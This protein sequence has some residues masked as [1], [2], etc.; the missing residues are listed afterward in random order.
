MSKP[1]TSAKLTIYPSWSI[2]SPVQVNYLI[3]AN[4]GSATL[5]VRPSGLHEVHNWM[6][7]HA[8]GVKLEVEDRV[9]LNAVKES[10]VDELHLKLN[11][12]LANPDRLP[13][14]D[15]LTMLKLMWQIFPKTKDGHTIYP[16][17]YVWWDGVAMYADDFYPQWCW[18]GSVADDHVW[19][20]VADE[21]VPVDVSH[22]FVEEQQHE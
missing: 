20:M 19:L 11:K 16:N 13:L 22:V 2:H 7:K 8:R 9:E 12:D 6:E 18:V 10:T 17:K 15:S 5:P 1:F 21:A 14:M 3:E 4:N